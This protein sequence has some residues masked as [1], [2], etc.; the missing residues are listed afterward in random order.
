MKI[1]STLLPALAFLA[2]STQALLAQGLSV[3]DDF[4]G[5]SLNT[6]KWFNDATPVTVANSRARFRLTAAIKKEARSELIAYEAFSGDFEFVLDFD[7]YSNTVKLGSGLELFVDGAENPAASNK[8]VNLELVSYYHSSQYRIIK[9]FSTWMSDGKT[10][11]Q[12]KGWPITATSGQ[13][14]IKRDTKGI[15]V[16]T[17]TGTQTAFRLIKTWPNVL[18]K[19]VHVGISTW[20][21]GKTLNSSG[22][23]AVDCDKISAAGKR[24]P[25]PINYGKNCHGILTAPA[26]LPSLGN[27]N[28]GYFLGGNTQLAGSP[29]AMILGSN[30]QNLVLAPSAPACYLNTNPILFMLGTILNKQGEGFVRLPVPNDKNLV[31]V[32]VKAQHL[33]IKLGINKLGLAFTQGVE[34]KIFKL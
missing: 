8:Y 12:F 33:I 21:G 3:Y 6:Q 15:S 19:L 25:G 29:T 4:T 7:K 18:P 1:S 9:E 28:F 2:I 11:T 24:I 22:K 31:G 5:T 14:R 27:A 17:R 13:M 32:N 16:Y 30:K 34:T 26:G 23:F 20:S 10:E